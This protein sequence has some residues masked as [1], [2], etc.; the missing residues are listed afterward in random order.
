MAVMASSESDPGE[1][2]LPDPGQRPC[3]VSGVLFDRRETPVATGAVAEGCV[4]RIANHLRHLSDWGQSGW[5]IGDSN[6][7]VVA[8]AL[9]PGVDLK[10]VFSSEPLEDIHWRVTGGADARRDRMERYGF[11][12]AGDHWERD[13]RISSP[14]DAAAVARDVVGVLT[15]CFGYDGQ[16]TLTFS[17]AQTQRAEPGLVYR[18]LTPD[19]FRKLLLGWGHA[20]ELGATVSGNPV[21]RAAAAGHKFHVLFAWPSDDGRLYGC[22]NFITVFAARPG[23]TLDAVNAI[24]QGSRFGRLYLDD[25]GDLILERDISLTGGVAVG[26]L[27]ECLLDWAC[28]M[29]SARKKLDK[30]A[31]PPVVIH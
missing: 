30:L 24:S 2:P 27:Q 26:Y 18:A 23:L 29:E 28:M 9:R 17:L 31:S 21:I 14:Q 15:E 5:K 25:D 4:A 1:R 3:L 11:A 16:E 10:S 13:V 6:E 8:A 12:A 22:L 19:D 7:Y 20:A